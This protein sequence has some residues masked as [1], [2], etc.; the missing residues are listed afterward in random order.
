M[1]ECRVCSPYS[2][3]CLR[4]GAPG[5][6]RPPPPTPAGQ[7]QKEAPGKPRVSVGQPRACLSKSD[8]FIIL[9]GPGL[10]AHSDC[11][12]SSCCCC[13]NRHAWA[14]HAQWAPP[15]P[16]DHF[17]LTSGWWALG[18][19]PSLPLPEEIWNV[20][21]TVRARLCR[22][23]PP[24]RKEESGEPGEAQDR[25]TAGPWGGVGSG[26]PRGGRQV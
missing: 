4:T 1:S 26:G 2:L 17:L 8:P 14:S 3:R 20:R 19:L 24:T 13:Q 16:R 6:P 5:P 15:E 9:P 21:S 7:C 22:P 11:H 18:G 23:G 25:P 12:R 10:S